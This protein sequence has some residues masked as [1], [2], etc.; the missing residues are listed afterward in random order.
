MLARMPHGGKRP[1]AGRPKGS[2]NRR[3]LM[4][5][6][7]LPRLDPATFRLPLYELM[8]R[9]ADDTLDMRYRDMLRLAVLPYFHARLPP[10]MAANPPYLMT[11]AELA[12][13]QRA[14]RE[15]ERQIA[16]GRGQVRLVKPGRG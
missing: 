4:R 8:E 5:T 10:T 7:V 9:I 6:D 15:H 11:D 16:L 12:D 2:R 13:V 3:V 1:G 14:Q